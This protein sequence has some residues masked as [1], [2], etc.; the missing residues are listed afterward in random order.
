[1]LA[2]KPSASPKSPE[3]ANLR[4]RPRSSSL[5]EPNESDQ[6][7]RSRQGADG[8]GRIV[9]NPHGRIPDPR[10]ARTRLQEHIAYGLGHTTTTTTMSVNPHAIYIRHSIPDFQIPPGSDIH[11]IEEA[12]RRLVRTGVCKSVRC[13]KPAEVF[14]CQGCRLCSAAVRNGLEGGAVRKESVAAVWDGGGVGSAVRG[15]RSRRLDG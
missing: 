1:M 2:T 4:L 13:L 8:N 10:S 11:E 7:R 6:L 3:N 15:T 9:N 12:A 14:L 5:L